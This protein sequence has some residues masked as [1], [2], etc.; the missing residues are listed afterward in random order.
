[1][2]E[3]VDFLRQGYAALQRDDLEA[4]KALARGHLDPEFEFHLVWDGRVLK[5]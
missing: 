3:R 4:F 5:G 1:M 2:P